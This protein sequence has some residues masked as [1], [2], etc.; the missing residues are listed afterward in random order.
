MADFDDRDDV[1]DGADSA[2]AE[3][4]AAL[5]DNPALREKTP[6]PQQGEWEDFD[7]LL[8]ENPQLAA[9]IKLA[10]GSV[11]AFYYSKDRWECR[12]ENEPVKTAIE[13]EPVPG[14]RDGIDPTTGQI[15]PDALLINEIRGIC[16]DCMAKW[17]GGPNDADDE[18]YRGGSSQ[19]P[20]GYDPTG[21]PAG[22]PAD[23]FD[24]D[25][26]DDRHA[27][28]GRRMGELQIDEGPGKGKYTSGGY[29]EPPPSSQNQELY[30]DDEGGDDFVDD[31]D[32]EDESRPLPPDAAGGPPPD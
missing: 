9:P 18:P 20:A 22:P 30:D 17:A 27:R 16:P 3:L 19:D 4:E 29:D 7:R 12:H 10:R 24:D 15:H 2:I 21:V 8:A 11:T 14:E 28:L 26:E 1:S 6:P 32:D 31:S 23:D 5:R 25:Y 13:R